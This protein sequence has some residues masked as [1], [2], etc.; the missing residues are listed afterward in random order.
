MS[1]ICTVAGVYWSQQHERAEAW[2][3]G[4]LK[5]VT[6]VSLSLPYLTAGV[7]DMRALDSTTLEF[8]AYDIGQLKSVTL[9]NWG[10]QNWRAEACDILQLD[11]RT[12]DR[13]KL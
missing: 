6:L 10:Q 4:Q 3:F 5:S 11:P 1:L 2:D 13:W 12:L 9:N 8:G 7:S